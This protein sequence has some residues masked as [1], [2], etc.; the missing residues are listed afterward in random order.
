M[1]FHYLRFP[2]FIIPILS[3]RMLTSVRALQLF[4]VMRFGAF[5]LTGILFTK[6]GLG[7]YSIGL[8]EALLFLGS[9]LSFFWLSGLS[10]SL[11]AHYS[12]APRSTEFFNAFLVMLGCSVLVFVLFRLLV[13]PYS[14]LANNPEI[15]AY[16]GTF[17]FYVLLIGPVFLVEYILL[18]KERSKELLVYGMFAFGGQ[19]ALVTL[20]IL[21]G[22]GLEEAILGLTISAALRFAVLLVL[23]AKYAAFTIDKSFLRNFLI[24]ASPLI[25]GAL[26]SGS[27]EYVDGFIVSHY[28]NEQTFA[29]YRYGAK[30]FPL[31]LLLANAFSNGMVPKVSQDVK[32]GLTQIRQ[33]SL[34]MM[35]AFFPLSIG[36][37]VV[38]GWLYPKLFSAEFAQSASVFNVYLLLVISRVIFPQTLLIGL[39]HAKAIMYVSMVEITVNVGLSL[40]FVQW[41]GLVGI[42]YATV[43]AFAME[44]LLL[45]FI[46]WHKE[47]ISPLSYWPWKM[48]LIYSVV[49][50]G[51]HAV[52]D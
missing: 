8:Y 23:L 37:M 17:S 44:K 49:L 2:I 28:F 46:L 41:F 10:Q 31:V 30:E 40:L 25:A 20:P 27:A 42:A 50:L 26:L 21:L 33:G 48:H 45:M 35:H 39:R 19:L 3:L 4:Q 18:L 12:P 1:L 22:Y 29:I 9:L 47:R 6:M 5:F 11:L 13:T 51:V 14:F 52:I 43:V 36:L 7:A 16:Y 24:T 15:L 32:A 34:Q 38:S